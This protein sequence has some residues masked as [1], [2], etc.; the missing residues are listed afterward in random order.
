MEL[1]KALQWRY[2]VHQ[3]TDEKISAEQ[4][5]NLLEA[6]RLAPTSYGLQ[7]FKV[8]VLESESIRQQLVE[9]S[10]R[11]DKILKSSHLIV[12]A[13]ETEINDVTIDRYF[14]QCQKMTGRTVAE[15]EAYSNHIKKSFT[16]K[17]ALQKRLWAQQQTFIAFGQFLTSAAI[18]KIDC[19]PIGGFEANGYD[20]VLQLAEQGLTATI[21]SPIG[22]RHP[23]D[24]HAYQPKIRRDYHDLVR[25]L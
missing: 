8:L 21:V 3:F 13:S 11:Q 23:E 10:Y 2:A 14:T 4:I 22:V 7:P 18:L 24:K 12:F 1:L 9:H 20:E 6:T 16:E 17:T 25:E 19:C 5:Q 15:Y